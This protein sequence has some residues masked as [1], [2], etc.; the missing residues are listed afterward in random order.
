MR[1]VSLITALVVAAV[2][3]GLVMKR[4]E[5]LAFAGVAAQDAPAPE[6]V[7]EPPATDALPE[8]T[9]RVMAKH[10][11]AQEIDSAVVLRGETEAVRQVEV[12]AE[13]AG[14]I[15]SPPLRAGQMVEAGQLLCEIDP[16]TRQVQLREAEAALATARAG[17]PESIAR[18]AEARAQLPAAEAA[19]AQAEAAIPAAEAQLAQARAGLPAAEASLKEAQAAVPAA[20]AA[21]AEAESRLPETEAR[22]AEAQSRLKEAEINLT[23]AQKLAQGGFAAQTRLAGAEADYESAKAGVQTAL[24]GQKTAATGVET[25]R[26]QLEGAHARVESARSQVET[27]RAAVETATSGIANAK[28][29]L[30]S[31]KAQ[32]ESAAAAVQAAMTGEES[33]RS[34]IQS[35]EAAVASGQN[36]LDRL[37][38]HAPFGGLLETDTA[39]LGALMQTGSACATVIQLDPIKLVGFAPETEIARVKDGARAGARMV[40][41]REITGTVS[42]VSR[43]A[44]PV[45]R[46]FR[47]EIT[48]PNADL[49]IRDGQ[50]VEIAI[51]ADGAPAHLLAQSTLT[52]N[53]EGELG[54]RTISDA[55]EALFMPV[56]LL[57]D[58]RQGVWVTGLPDAVDV[59]TVGQEYVT[60]GVPVAPSFEEILQ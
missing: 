42:F 31:A 3:F 20:E 36:E 26:S 35:A 40:D 44:D 41:G 33:A 60:D 5:M 29:G 6:E 25:A 1:F 10:S 49:S 39:E 27:A 17:L 22:L 19:I 24:T 37:A 59:I 48:L 52:L 13:T 54:V 8:G 45:T 38:I 53:D 56:T 30:A 2:L 21:L 11:V 14:K 50:T 23:A 55:S 7:A 9:V 47:V 46:T 58:T 43:S 57:R 28:A 16:G 32:K 51:E 4:E 34:A 15:I 18:L 12:R